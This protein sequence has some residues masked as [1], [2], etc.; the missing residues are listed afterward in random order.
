ML[1]FTLYNKSSYNPAFSSLPTNS[2]QSIEPN[3]RS[4]AAIPSNN[5]HLTALSTYNKAF[6]KEKKTISFGYEFFLKDADELLHCAYCKRELFTRPKIEFYSKL[7]S[8]SAGQDVIAFL[9]ELREGPV[10][11]QIDD[12]VEYLKNQSFRQPNLKFEDLLDSLAPR[13]EVNLFR[14]QQKIY[15]SIT[16]LAEG[17]P[18]T[19]RGQIANVFQDVRNGELAKRRQIFIG[20]YDIGATLYETGASDEDMKI[21]DEIMNK[22]R[23]MPRSARNLDAFIYKN[24]R[25]K[26]ENGNLNALVS[27]LVYPLNATVEHVFPHSLIES[28]SDEKFINSVD[29]YLLA[30]PECNGSRGNE[31]FSDWINKDLIRKFRLL[32]CLKESIGVT[33]KPTYIG[34]KNYP[35]KICATINKAY[36]EG[37]GRI[38]IDW[39]NGNPILVG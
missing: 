37:T 29:N 19:A 4:D 2:F 5:L 8:S 23:N 17:L 33:Q 25:E 11:H 18:Y 14:K 22:A 39:N 3:K 10:F 6:I 21:L 34:Y 32:E 27:Q 15:E 28:G 1:G 20:L 12:S 35:K 36:R 30:C 16:K 9:T 38:L 26:A 13:H 24:W 31:P 7:L